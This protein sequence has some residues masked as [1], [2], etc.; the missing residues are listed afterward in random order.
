MLTLDGLSVPAVCTAASHFPLV[1]ARCEM[2][3]S[4]WLHAMKTTQQLLHE[5]WWVS[6]CSKQQEDSQ[7]LPAEIGTNSE[8]RVSECQKYKPMQPHTQQPKKWGH[9]S[10]L[11]SYQT[12]G[13]SHHPPV[14]TFSIWGVNCLSMY[15]I[16]HNGILTSVVVGRFYHNKIIIA[17]IIIIISNNYWEKVDVVQQ[18]TI[19][20]ANSENRSLNITG[21]CYRSTDSNKFH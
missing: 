12:L 7:W 1:P 15:N 3:S 14:P 5:K 13:K 9:W 11:A 20:L 2:L 10:W 19:K 21:F 16:H 18:P 4:N 8:A 6:Y 17:I